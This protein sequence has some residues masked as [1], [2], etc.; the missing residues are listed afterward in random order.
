MLLGALTATAGAETRLGVVNAGAVL[1]L[2]VEDLP[3]LGRLRIRIDGTDRDDLTLSVQGGDLL[4][5]LPADLSGVS[6]D[7]VV[8][9]RRPD[10][11][12][13]LK[14]FT[15]ETPSGATSYAISG[16]VEAGVLSGAAGQHGYAVGDTR[17]SFELD[18]GRLTGGLVASRQYDLITGQH[19]LKVADYFLQ[20]RMAV[21][22][23]DLVLRLGSQ[24]LDADLPLFDDAARPGISLRLTDADRR[25]ETLAFAS[26]ASP[27]DDRHSLL[28][29]RDSGDRLMGLRGMVYPLA[30]RGLKLS[31]AGFSGEVPS[32]AS[33][34]PG[35]NEGLA[36]QISLPF[37]HDLG[38]VSLSY[39]HS[40]SDDG[41]PISGNALTA[42]L[43]LLAT[44]RDQTQSLTFTLR[45]K[46]VDAGFYSALNPDLIADEARS[47]FE[48]QWYAPQFQ[49][50]LVYGKATD[51]IAHAASQPTDQFRDATLTLYYSPQDFTGGFWNG[52]SLSLALHGEDQLR[53]HSPAGAIAPQDNR[54][55]SLEFGIDHFRAETSWALHYSYERLTDLTG[56]G[57][58]QSARRFEALF[59]YELEDVIT[60]N[61][62]ADVAQI[63]TG[64][65]SYD[66]R[67]V[68]ASLWKQLVPDLLS[69]Q[70]GLGISET[71]LPG[72]ADGRYL[73][74]E[75]AW[76]FLPE[77]E[78]VLSAE[79]GEGSESLA[80]APAGGWVVGLAYRQDFGFFKHN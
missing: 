18:R 32:L 38:S 39:A 61:L 47:E 69:G 4:V 37:A 5:S 46:T 76:E 74:S 20:R 64:G 40:L 19:S 48:A 15:F 78:L 56:G 79:Y 54:F 45:R 10:S 30:G 51:N 71:N 6:H 63:E 25:Y 31:Y 8:L 60:L 58:G 68:S 24:N 44:P 14:T 50:D 33:G 55:E 21:L 72:E 1:R 7:L 62:A 16:S 34:K 26:Q 67:S 17:I 53:R 11:D 2:Q 22:G 43:S 65:G 35:R 80:L 36:G 3:P 41:T 75:L 70:I 23:D 73:S 29:L 66:E 59:A 28:G 13:A 52:T 49:A 12:I 9:Q 42:E 57:G 27:W 77:K